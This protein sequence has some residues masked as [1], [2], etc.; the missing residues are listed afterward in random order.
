MEHLV[1]WYIDTHRFYREEVARNLLGEGVSIWRRELE[2][3][4]QEGKLKYGQRFMT[5]V[6]ARLRAQHQ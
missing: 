5:E 2:L 6:I 1:N 4:E 3:L